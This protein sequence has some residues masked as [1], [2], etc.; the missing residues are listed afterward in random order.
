MKDPIRLER[1]QRWRAVFSTTEGESVLA[2]LRKM[3]GQDSSTAMF[4]MVEDMLDPYR[5]ILNEGRRTVWLDIQKCLTEPPD[6]PEGEV[7]EGED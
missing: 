6:M 1:Y 4:S 7:D 3:T 2:D 5:T